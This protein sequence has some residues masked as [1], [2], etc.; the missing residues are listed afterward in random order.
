[1]HSIES[2]IESK[3]IGERRIEGNSLVALSPTDQT[4]ATSYDNPPHY[5]VLFWQKVEEGEALV[6]F[7]FAKL[8]RECMHCASESWD[9]GTPTLEFDLRAG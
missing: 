1:M 5:G 6:S 9:D 3:Q 7:G 8:H 2:T 4:D